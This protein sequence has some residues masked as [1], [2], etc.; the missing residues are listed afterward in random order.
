MW[1]GNTRQEL[2]LPKD[3]ETHVEADRWMEWQAS[4]NGAPM[5]KVFW[6]L[7]R[8]HRQISE[9]WMKLERR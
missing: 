8:A 5:V 7:V 3:E 4:D 9:T 1:H 6:G 2:L